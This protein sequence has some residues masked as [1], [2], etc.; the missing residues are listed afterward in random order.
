MIYLIL[1]A[2]ISLGNPVDEVK[3]ESI[4]PI[5]EALDRGSS[6]EL[7]Q[8]FD[9][10]IQLNL[11]GKQGSYSSSQAEQVLKEFF[12]QNPPNSFAVVYSSQKNS[13]VNSYVGNYQS[14]NRLFKVFLKV[15]EKD[16]S[17]RLYSLEFVAG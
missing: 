6:S 11:N 8:Y 12:R 13:R 2:F 3:V 1:A 10:S 14:I 9:S 15:N 5:V 4:D 17:I 7:A 16:N